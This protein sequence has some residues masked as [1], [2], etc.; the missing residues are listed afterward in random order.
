M[1]VVYNNDINLIVLVALISCSSSQILEGIL[2]KPQFMPA[3]MIL[4]SVVIVYS[5][6]NAIKVAN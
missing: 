1:L 2:N 3:E 4:Y 5:F 6:R